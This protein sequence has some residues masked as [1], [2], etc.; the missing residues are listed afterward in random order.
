MI[1]DGQNVSDHGGEEIQQETAQELEPDC[2]ARSTLMSCEG[3]LLCVVLF[4]CLLLKFREG[5]IMF[6]K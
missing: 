4:F 2:R 6:S 5:H 1:R 3:S